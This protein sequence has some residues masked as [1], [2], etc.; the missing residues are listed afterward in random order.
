[1]SNIIQI[2]LIK[3]VGYNIKTLQTVLTS[4]FM[5]IQM[6]NLAAQ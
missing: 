6:K 1:M 3:Y 4:K 2:F 5:I